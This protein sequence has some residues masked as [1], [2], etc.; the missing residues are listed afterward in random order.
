MTDLSVVIPVYNEEASH[1]PLWAELRGV[2]ER[3]G[4]SFEVVFVDDGSRDRSAEIIRSFRETDLSIR[5]KHHDFKLRGDL[6]EDVPAWWLL[7]KKKTMYH[8]GTADARGE[9]PW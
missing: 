6:C 4:V 7:K 3:L 2:L 1:S 9:F 8:T 5:L